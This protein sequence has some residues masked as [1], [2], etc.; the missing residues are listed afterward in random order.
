MP[1]VIP[2][3]EEHRWLTADPAERMSMCQPYADDDLTAYQIST[4]V[5]NPANDNP[6]VIEPLGHERSR[7]N[8]F[9]T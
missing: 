1:V 2:D 9:S 3:G 4:Q 6:S 5:T 7:L 8:E